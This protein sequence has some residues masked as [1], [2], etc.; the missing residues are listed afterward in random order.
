[1]R[2]R[3]VMVTTVVVSLLGGA[4]LAA[5]TEDPPRDAELASLSVQTDDAPIVDE[6]ALTGLRRISTLAVRIQIASR[7]GERF[8]DQRIARDVR[9]LA[10]LGWFA[11]IRVSV[12]GADGLPD[13]PEEDPQHVR[14]VFD[15][16]EN[17]FLTGVEYS[18]SRLLS[19]EQVAKLVAEKKL[20]PKLG[21]P[22][23]LA[24][25]Q[26]IGRAIRAA[27][28]ALGHPESRVEIRRV[29]AANATVR[30]RFEIADGPHLSVSRVTFEGN[31]EVSAKLLQ[32]Q[33]RR[34]NAG[35]LFGSLQG[36]NSYTREALDE[37]REGLLAYYQNHG[38]PEA[39]IGDAQVSKYAESS[40]RWIPWPRASG[41]NVLT[42]KTTA[43]PP[44]TGTRMIQA[45]HGEAGVWRF[46]S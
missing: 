31:P 29:L 24:T 5:R 32:R 20:T 12:E 9:A 46:A 2:K 40:Q 26:Q 11:A 7:A 37:D 1:M 33:M 4:T 3:Q 19:Q 41:A 30:V 13:H 6:I 25:M 44:I 34:I 45:P 28:A 17:P 36:K 23:N 38:Y 14:L 18:G 35:A 42:R 16:Q 21:E 39:R 43:I 8:D 15:L 10:K 22:E 27:L